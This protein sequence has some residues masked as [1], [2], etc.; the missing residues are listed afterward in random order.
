MT[1]GFALEKNPKDALV[2]A[3]NN[4]SLERYLL[5]CHYNVFL[6][7]KDSLMGHECIFKYL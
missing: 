4:S 1:D 3:L 7:K 2:L 5:S 6:K